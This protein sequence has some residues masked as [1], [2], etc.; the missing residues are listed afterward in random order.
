[1]ADLFSEFRLRGT[2]LRNRIVVSPMCQY[3][4]H[5]G[6]AND[7][8]LVH[9]GRF[10]QGGFGL[11]IVE[12][13][14][15]VP[16]GRIT[17]ADLGLWSDAHIAPLKRIVDFVHAQGA[18]IGIQLAHAGRKASAAPPW[19]GGKALEGEAARRQGAE[20]WQPVAPSPEP[21]AEGS[22]LPAE[23]SETDIKQTVNAFAA[24]AERAQMAGFDLIEIHGAHGYLIDQFL[25]PLANKRTDAYG[26]P[27]ENRMRFALEVVEAVRKVWPNE[28]P[29]F[30]RLSVQDW[31]PQGWQVEDSVELA[32]QVGKRGVDL[33][34]CSSGGFSGAKVEVG[35]EYQVPFAQAIRA[36]ANIPTMAV[37]LI[38]TAKR[39]QQ[40]V[41]E[42]KA[43][44]VALARAALDDPNW[45]LH[46]RH[47]LSET[48]DDP[49]T[50]WPK[51][52]GYAIKARDRSLGNAK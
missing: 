25:S 4:A 24:A 12:A 22:P 44:L 49:Y 27:R 29:A 3:S 14:A 7:W 30:M 8:H 6:L 51:Q 36:E 40:I 43:D 48:A 2:T 20:F 52:A 35:F 5:M 11:V 45:P 17:Y 33:I 9:L 18:A 10:A 38:E 28:K 31:H 34:D 13:A 32:K 46:A 41:Q 47:A 23:M 16:E 19:L 21:H 1:M 26:G 39:A 42:G 50:H 37:G 15:V